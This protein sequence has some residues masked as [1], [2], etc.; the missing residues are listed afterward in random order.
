MSS[1]GFRKST[2]F[3]IS[4]SIARQLVGQHGELPHDD[5][6]DPAQGSEREGDREDDRG[7]PRHPTPLEEP[8]KRR[9]C[10]AEE[11]R[12]GQ[13][14][15][16]LGRER[17]RADDRQDEEGHDGRM[18]HR[19]LASSGHG[20]VPVRVT[21]SGRTQRARIASPVISPATRPMPKAA[22]TVSVGWWRTRLSALS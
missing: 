6:A 21:R 12:Q 2:F 9:Q 20:G 8:R 13:G 19:G 10:E 11:H 5:V 18:V 1:D 7:G 16:H 3:W 15:E 14:L 4:F 17:H 22:T